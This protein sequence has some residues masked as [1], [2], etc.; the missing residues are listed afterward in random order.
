ME[1]KSISIDILRHGETTAGASFVGTTDVALTRTGWQQMQQAIPENY[2]YDA[3]ISSP[4]K[5]CADFAR[6]FSIQHDIP[7]VFEDNFREMDFGEWEGHSSE[8]VWENDRQALL[9]FWQDPIENSPTGGE[10]IVHFHARVMGAFTRMLREYENKHLLLVTHVGPIRSML[11]WLM[12]ASLRNANRINISQGGVSR[13]R[14][15]YD[16]REYYPVIEYIN[17]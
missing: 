8:S 6:A 15:A 12:D 3:I 1:N 4:L 5:R 7:L 14:V 17:R 16:D 10:N 11:I 2:G 9:A 13:I